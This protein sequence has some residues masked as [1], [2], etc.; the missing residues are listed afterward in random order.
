MKII[1]YILSF[2]V[3]V[4]TL[5]PCIDQP[6]DNTL[7]KNEITQSTNSSNHQDETD[8]CSPFCTCQCCQTNSNI[9]EITTTTPIVEFQISY[10]EHSSN[11]LSFN[12][13]DFFIPPK[14]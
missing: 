11:F 7:L 6:M 9:S 10:N 3:L 4:L 1:A 8:H 2:L 14:S 13:F 5:V 12:F